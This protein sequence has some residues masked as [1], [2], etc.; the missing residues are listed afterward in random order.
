MT[1]IRRSSDQEH[2]LPDD[3]NDIVGR[4]EEVVDTTNS[5][6]IQNFI[7]KVLAIVCGEGIEL[8]RLINSLP[9]VTSATGFGR[10]KTRVLMFLTA[11]KLL[12][13]SLIGMKLFYSLFIFDQSNCILTQ[14]PCCSTYSFRNR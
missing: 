14:L 5:E 6:E 8:V 2:V 11:K 13:P 4:E 7:E 10:T 3:E 9:K 1:T 12:P